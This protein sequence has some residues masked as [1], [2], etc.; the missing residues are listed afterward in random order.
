M[1]VYRICKSVYADDLTGKGAKLYG[2]RWNRPGTAVLYTSFARSLA[3]LELFVHFNAKDALKNDYSII[4]LE[5]PDSGLNEI[6]I[7]MIPHNDLKINDQR[8]W[9]LTENFFFKKDTLVLKVPSMVVNQEYNYLINP[10]HSD[11]HNIKVLNVESFSLDRRLY[12]V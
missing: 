4:E 5:I 6:T 11:F 8:L 2:G 12:L 9:D 3:I 1:I 7:N 10:L